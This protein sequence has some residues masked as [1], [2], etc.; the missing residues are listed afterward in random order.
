MADTVNA[1]QLRTI[2]TQACQAIVDAKELLGEADR[3][4]GDGDHGT[5]MS[6]GFGA[7]LEA[8]K[9]AELS[10]VGDAF[11]AVGMAVLST[12]GGA[13]GAVFGTMFRAPA[14]ALGGEEMDAEGYAAGL[15]AAVEKVMARGKAEPGQKTMLDALIPAAEAA[16]ASVSEGLAASSCAAANAAEQGSE[17][18]K[19]MIA[20]V[21]K[22]KS[23]GERS[24]GHK[25]PGSISVS[26][27]LTTIADGIAGA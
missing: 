12:S 7:G 6:R 10:T 27:L 19:D 13:S 9:D 15:E 21:G 5:G 18:T 26:I 2:L 17:A 1:E 8:L 22:A 25:D 4:T 11:K 14:K 3:A 24:L 20:K 16:R 23:L